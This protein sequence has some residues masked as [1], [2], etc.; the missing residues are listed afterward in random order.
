M[1]A[2]ITDLLPAHGTGTT[3]SPGAAPAN[4]GPAGTRA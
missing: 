1:P 3:A 2:L 4:A